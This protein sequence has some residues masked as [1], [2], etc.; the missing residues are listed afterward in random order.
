[1]KP[2]HRLLYSLLALLLLMTPK[3]AAA[4]N[5]CAWNSLPGPMTYTADLGTLYVPKD[6]PLG[7]IIGTAD[8]F[9]S[10]QNNETLS[11]SCNNDGN[12]KLIFDTLTTGRL[13][14]NLFNGKFGHN[15]PNATMQTNIDGVSVEVRLG[16]PFTGGPDNAFDP[17]NNSIVPFRALHEKKMGSSNFQL[18]SLAGYY[19][20]TK[21]AA[22]AAGPQ[23][24]DGAELFSGHITTLGRIFGAGITG[25][26]IQAQCT[27][28]GN[29]VSADP[30][31]LGTWDKADFVGPGHTTA[32]VPFNITLSDCETDGLSTANIR[33]DGL[34][35]SMPVTPAISGVFSLSNDSTA[36]GVGIQILGS[37]G[38]TPIE[39]STEVPLMPITSGLTTLLFNARFYQ[40][41]QPEDVVRGLAKGALN[42]T[43]TYK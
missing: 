11:L 5:G 38:L 27:V 29:P 18:A 15:S 35:G 28:M 21:T 37:D 42:F 22:I 13:A 43:I 26:I 25:T 2:L 14:P 4:V 20:L 19:T 33:L 24:L 32:A 30:V 16:F 34:N 3:Q 10:T 7:S 31:V 6:A 41:G 12:Y 39:L 8:I 17:V 40:T 23:A 36:E 1:M 9:R